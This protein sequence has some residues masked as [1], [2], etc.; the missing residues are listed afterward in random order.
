MIPKRIFQTWKE[1]EVSNETLKSWQKSWI[2]NNPS[3]EYTIWDDNDNRKFIEENFP[4]FLPIYDNYDVNIKRVDAVRYFYLLKHG[5][6]YA[7]LDFICL[8]P[9]DDVLNIDADVVFGDLG[10]M[11]TAVNIYHSIPNAIMI[12]KEN[13]DFFRL[14]TLVLQNIGIDPKLCP[15]MA[16][17]PIL[18]KFCIIFYMTK[19]IPEEV[20]VVYNKNIFENVSD[21]ITFNDKIGITA[22]NI[23]YPINWDKREHMQYRQKLRS[24]DELKSLFP[25]SYAVT[26]WM[27]SW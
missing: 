5:G 26:Y 13:S 16:T 9:F 27:H 25:D 15:E 23:F 12:S 14:V 6:V 24:I 17:G 8:K 18:L 20:F 4:H 21:K 10:Q 19:T 7:D 2:E 11:D 22:P 1:K 3:Y